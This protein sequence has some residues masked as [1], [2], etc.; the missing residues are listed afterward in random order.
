MERE[1]NELL[2]TLFC[3]GTVRG[4]QSL[5]APAKLSLGNAEVPAALYIPEEE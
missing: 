1:I 4:D 3:V 2:S 5:F